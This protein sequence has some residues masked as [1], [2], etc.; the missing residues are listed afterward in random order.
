M[1]SIGICT[2]KVC[3]D[4]VNLYIP[5]RFLWIQAIFKRYVQDNGLRKQ[6]LRT[7][8]VCTREGRMLRVKRIS[9]EPGLA[10]RED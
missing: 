9:A 8:E 3:Y 4:C 5:P 10:A 1:E 6:V 7:Y 2:I